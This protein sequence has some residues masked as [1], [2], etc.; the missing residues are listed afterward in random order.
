MSKKFGVPQS[1]LRDH[2]KDS[3]RKIGAG[4]PTIFAHMEEKE[5]VLNLQALQEIG[6][7]LTR[8]LAGVVLHDYLSDQPCRP[9]PFKSNIPGNDWWM[10]F[11]KRWSKEL[12]W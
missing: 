1:T 2:L 4:H 11:M 10:L 6:F 12:S 5:V 3:S 8:E 9:N 7:G